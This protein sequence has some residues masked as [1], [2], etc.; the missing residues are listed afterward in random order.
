ML[1]SCIELAG[2]GNLW[3]CLPSQRLGRK[4]TNS[5][6]SHRHTMEQCWRMAYTQTAI[7]GNCAFSLHCIHNVVHHITIVFTTWPMLGREWSVSCVIP[8]LDVGIPT[9]LSST[10]FQEGTSIFLYGRGNILETIQTNNC[11]HPTH[12]IE[13]CPYSPSLHW[14]RHLPGNSSSTLPPG[15]VDQTASVHDTSCTSN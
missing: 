9:Q 13:L 14:L 11:L 3:P 12:C 8:T 2:W 15:P 7:D 1:P 6:M 4:K 10:H 5:P